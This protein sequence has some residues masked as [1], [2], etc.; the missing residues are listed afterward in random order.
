M[1]SIVKD[2]LSSIQKA[3]EDQQMFIAAISELIRDLP[4]E[5]VK[6]SR[7][8]DMTR[9][10]SYEISDIRRLTIKQQTLYAG[11]PIPMP[12]HLIT[13]EYA[14]KYSTSKLERSACI[15]LLQARPAQNS[16]RP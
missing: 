12:Y 10:I 3:K 8:D 7:P 1:F 4:P 11:G 9:I 15:S 14:D 16:K 13:G 5:Q 2:K 6:E